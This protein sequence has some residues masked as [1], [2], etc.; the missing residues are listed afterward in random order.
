MDPFIVVGIAIGFTVFGY[1]WGRG[2]GL[3]RQTTEA[4]TMSVM[5]YLEQQG[6][7][8]MEI[9]NGKPCYIKWPIANEKDL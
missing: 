3:T 7:L 5:D 9:I 8:R 1:V 2:A 6:Y 4:I